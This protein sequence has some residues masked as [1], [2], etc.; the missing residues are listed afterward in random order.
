MHRHSSEKGA[1]TMMTALFLVVIVGIAAMAVD[2]GMQRVSKRDMQ[3]LSDVVALDMARLLDGETQAGTLVA[4]QEWL[5]AQAQSVARN[6]DTLGITPTVEVEVGTL[7]TPNVATP[8]VRPFIPALPADPATVPTAVRVRSSSAVDFAF[9]PGRGS[10][11][12]A[13]IAESSKTACWQ[14]GSYAARFRSGDSALISTLVGPMNELIRP[15][16]NLDAVSYQGVANAQVTLNE[17]AADAAVGTT[18][19]LL[20]S[21]VTVSSLLQ[22]TIGALG[23][24]SPPNNVAISA[25][26]QML[27]GQASLSTPILLTNVISISPT[28]TAALETKLDVL[29]LITGSILVAD[30]QHAVSVPNLS[31]QVGGNLAPLTASAYI[32]EKPQMEC[33]APGNPT[34]HTETSQLHLDATMKLQAQ[35][36]NGITGVTG[37]VQTPESTVTIAVDVGR[38]EGD[39]VAPGPVCNAGTV[40]SPD[41]ET[42]SVGTGLTTLNISTTLHFKVDMNVLGVGAVEINFDQAATATQPVGPASN[43]TL[44][45]PPND[46]TPVSTGSPA[47][48]GNFTIATVATNVQATTKVLGV[49]VPVTGAPLD[50]VVSALATVTAQLAVNAALTQPLNGLVTNVNNLVTPLETLLGIRLGGADVWAIGRPTC[51][52]SR[53][54][55]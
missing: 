47:P 53:L 19:D 23:R 42:V 11:V 18:T 17:I 13:A 2:L 20:T 12:A 50:L 16:A 31:P 29:N 39:L 14:L 6:G 8:T 41:L 54:V 43:A 36:I 15:Q 5:D 7:G 48:F 45:I 24:Q 37:V 9:Y 22:A 34:A 33:T 10:V 30:G 38:A 27:N 28:N 4:S 25:L 49:D 1:V 32:I 52:G 26:N 3:A 21:T 46:T 51:R 35:S 55:G 40:A 44:L